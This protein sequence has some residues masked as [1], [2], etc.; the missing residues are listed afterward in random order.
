MRARLVLVAA[1][2][3]AATI[4]G[5]ALSPLSAGAAVQKRAT[6]GIEYPGDPVKEA[7]IVAA[8]DQRIYNVQ[9]VTVSAR[10][11]GI[12]AAAPYRLATGS[13][14]T[15]VLVARNAPYTLA[16]LQALEPERL[17]KQPDGSYLLSENIIIESG[18]TV[19]LASPDGLV[20][21]LASTSK[22]F[23]SIIALGGTLQLAGS[24]KAPV[25]IDSWDSSVGK[26][27]TVT[28]D[29]RA[30][31]RI[32]GGSAS[33]AYAAFD[34]LGFWSGSTGGL[35][36]TGTSTTDPTTIALGSAKGSA[37]LPTAPTAPTAGTDPTAT[38]DAEG[39]PQG[40]YSYVSARLDHV[41]LS[42]NA[43]G[44]FVNGAQGVSISNSTAR[45]NLVDGI[46]LHRYVTNSTIATTTTTRNG[47][48]GFSMSRAST[49]IVITQL[50]ANRNG[51]D[52]ISLNGGPLA[53]GP[54]ATGAP[55]GNYGN[56]SLGDS[57][58]NGNARYGV[59]VVGGDNVKILNNNTNNNL[60]GIVITKL[61]TGVTVKGN[62]VNDN[63][64]HGIALF[65][66]VSKSTVVEN[67]I[68]GADIGVY[69]RDSSADVL[70]NSISAVTN[71]GVTL[72]GATSAT[73]TDN[74]IGGRGTSAIDTVRGTGF[75]LHGNDLS[76]WTN[77]KPFWVTVR[78]IFQPLTVLWMVLGLT[79]LLT[80]AI[81]SR[82]KDRGA[83]RH[84]YESH[85]PLTSLSR[86][87]VRP[88][89]I[90]LEP[91]VSESSGVGHH[92]D[93]HEQRDTHKHASEAYARDARSAYLVPAQ[94]ATS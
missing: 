81:G 88:E 82:R 75:A 9:A 63:T 53:S 15:L 6:I 4:G 58:A 1:A 51:R 55:T 45:D 31:V 87:V 93:V 85:V 14:T 86:G 73:I 20:L 92:S 40:S 90:G 89:D 91:T 11:R 49:G 36:L 84:P 47:M 48:D 16:E 25:K 34:H 77:T 35:S 72:V 80:A 24:S 62:T 65:D 2:A 29:G 19:R 10:W 43:Y 46:V 30:Y 32:I 67:S 12:A 22:G 78:S 54:N 59:T 66:G 79:V 83:I 61:A 44:V 74:R 69:L 26:V 52:G 13:S 37:I 39:A 27:D 60:M 33:L 8:E 56:N 21:H 7:A 18:A 76:R 50:V 57:T 42:N 41:T 68:S 5:L 94:G 23:V 28:A 70:R 64:K 17:V 38:T 3:A 71:H